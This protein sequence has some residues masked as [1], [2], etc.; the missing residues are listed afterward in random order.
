M[1]ICDHRATGEI[2]QDAVGLQDAVCDDGRGGWDTVM[3]DA[4][5]NADQRALRKWLTAGLSIPAV[6][7]LHGDAGYLLNNM[8]A[9]YTLAADTY[10]ISAEALE[11]FELRGI[12]LSVTHSRRTFYGLQK[13]GN[14]FIYEHAVPAGVIRDTL[15]T[16][17][18]TA[19]AISQ[20]LRDA[21]PVAVLLRTEDARLREAGLNA[22][23]PG[24][25]VVGDDPLARYKEVG[26]VLSDQVL[27]VSGAICR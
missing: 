25:W 21:G 9:K 3:V 14:P 7:Q 8:I 22:R 11:E 26:I 23:M 18:R 15:L 10:T 13:G 20:T 4:T 5:E 12:D 27:R 17:P 19:D 16:G 1:T 24:G 6:V 2:L